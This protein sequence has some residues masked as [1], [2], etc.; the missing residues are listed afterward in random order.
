MIEEHSELRSGGAES[1][2]AARRAARAEARPRDVLH[3]PLPA[4]ALR[5]TLL[6]RLHQWW[7]FFVAGLLLLVVGPPVLTVS[8]LAR[9]REWVYP[10]AI[11]GG[12]AWLRLSG[13]R[14]VVRGRERLDPAATYIFISNHRSYL[15]TA[16]LF[17]YTG[18]R[19]GLLAKKEL[20]KVPILGTG[21]GFVN[22]MAIDRTN[23]QRAIETVRA[24]TERIRSGV[25]FGVFAE[26]TRAR[27]GELLPFKKGAFHMAID[28]GVRVVP[29][30]MKHTDVLMGKGTGLAR[31]GTIEMVILPPVETAGLS[32]AREEDVAKLIAQTRARIAVELGASDQP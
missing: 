12:K 13:M 14:V 6:R 28:A 26:G 20:L 22:I 18:R 4:D 31:P 16:T 23:R 27:P 15:D 3:T 32:T 2:T 25:S 21:M 9:R 1:I 7:V 30:A 19:I 5:P 10:W 17:D 11:W 24:A 8:W 29:V